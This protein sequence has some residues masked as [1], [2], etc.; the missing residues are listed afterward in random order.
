MSPRQDAPVATAV[1]SLRRQS[2]R[3]LRH[4][5]Y[6]AYFFGQSLSLIGT[7]IQQVALGWL[8]VQDF[9]HGHG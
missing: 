6:R 8:V 7:W 1:A 5:A 4:P 2:W 9:N 3:A